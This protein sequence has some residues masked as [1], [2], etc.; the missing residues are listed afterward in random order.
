MKT[1][2]IKPDICV[3]NTFFASIR[4]V[5]KIIISFPLIV[6]LT[7]MCQRHDLISWTI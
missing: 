3:A 1:L 6:Q 4:R 2:S 5:H 7:F